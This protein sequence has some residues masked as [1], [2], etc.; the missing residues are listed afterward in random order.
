[1]QLQKE[2]WKKVYRILSE[3]D[4]FF[5]ASAITFNIF[6]CSIPFTLILISIIGYI[7][8]Y[9]TAFNE[10]IR[11]GT[12]LIPVFS[13]E[14]STSETIFGQDTLEGILKPLVGARNIFG[15]TGLIILL[16]FT[17]GLLHSFKHVI[18]DIFEIKDRKHPIKD[19]LYNFLGFGVIGA[20]F[21][22]FSLAIS[23]ISILN[24]S[25]IKV[26]YTDFEIELP[27]IYDILDFV[28]PIVLTF[29]LVFAIFRFVSERRIS[30][31]VALTGATIY[32]ILFE[33]AKVFVSLYLSYAFSTY[34]F[35]Y[36]GYAIFVV[37]GIWAFYTSLIF[38]FSVILTRA[39]KE[40]YFVDKSAVEDNPYLSLD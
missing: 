31:K 35:F 15:I 29:F 2:F 10:I 4:I 26:P 24:L 20:V 28:L 9:D 6:I 21:L 39:I 3:K 11:Y 36:Q 38:I 12:E 32:T 23:V 25:V 5:N 14:N 1:M 27:W 7:L 22:F 19:I 17:Q 13:Q 18:F 33:L 37:I 34:Q 40:T 30:T 8:S 16:F